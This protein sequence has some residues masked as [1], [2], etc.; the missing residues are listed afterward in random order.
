MNTAACASAPLSMPPLRSAW[1]RSVSGG[2]SIA[3]S[4]ASRNSRL[5]TSE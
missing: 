2:F 5:R 4:M 3:G 1:L